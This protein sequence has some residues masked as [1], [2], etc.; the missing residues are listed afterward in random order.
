MHNKGTP[1]DVVYMYCYPGSGGLSRPDRLRRGRGLEKIREAWSGKVR[2]AP[3]R[4]LRSGGG[5]SEN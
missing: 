4:F 2:E 1:S 3:G 5:K